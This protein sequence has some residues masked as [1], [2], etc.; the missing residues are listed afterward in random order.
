MKMIA[1]NKHSDKLKDWSVEMPN[2]PECSKTFG[3]IQDIKNVG[4]LKKAI[5]SPEF[6]TYWF[7]NKDNCNVCKDCEYRYIC[8]DYYLP[9]K[10]KNRDWYFKRT[11]TYNPYKI[12]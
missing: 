7:I 9:V 4:E 5:A 8:L 11:C 6:Q 12:K 3:F 1:I 10:G 2:A